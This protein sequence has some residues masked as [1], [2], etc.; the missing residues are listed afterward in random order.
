VF[1]FLS[2]LYFRGKLAYA[3]RFARGGEGAAGV[4]VITPG[5]GLRPPDEPITAERLRAFA[6]VAVDVTSRRYRTAL[7]RDAGA[8]AARLGPDDEVVLLGSLASGKYVQLL[9]PVLGPRLRAPVDFVGLGDMSRGALL[10][11][12]VREGRELAY[13][14]V[15]GPLRAVR[16]RPASVAPGPVNP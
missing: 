5:D 13:A 11:R 1:A 7:V 9:A 15:S 8:L 3:M 2:G 16:G 4:L 10:L 12:C 14:T 6:R